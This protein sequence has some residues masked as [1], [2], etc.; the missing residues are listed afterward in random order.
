MLD[1]LI[2]NG[3]VIDGTGRQ[4]FRAGVG[5]TAGAIRLFVPPQP[6]PRARKIIDASGMVVA[7][8]F[9][10]MHGHSDIAL[11]KR[12]AILAK[13]MQGV[14][15]EV[16]G[17]CGFSPAP[18]TRETHALVRDLCIPMFG[19]GSV[20]WR[21]KRFGEFLRCFERQ[22]PVSN[23]VALVG[24][25]PVRI[26]A[27][28]LKKKRV[29][30]RAMKRMKYLL[31]EALSEGARGMSSGLIY[32]PGF[33]STEAELTELCKVVARHGGIYATHMR[34]EA[35]RLIESIEESIRTAAE[36]GVSLQI[37]HLKAAQKPNWGKSGEALRRI[38]KARGE[39]VD[40][41]FD[42]YPYT[43]GSTTLV[44]VLPDW[45]HEGG[46]RKL[47]KRV[48]TSESRGRL[49][50]EL[51]TN[52][53]SYWKSL[54]I[55]SVSTR[56]NK[57]FEG[58]TLDE[59]SQIR[60]CAP[61]EAV[62]DIIAEENGKV[63]MIGFSMCEEDVRQILKEPTGMI[64]TDG[65]H[66]SKP[67]PRLYGAFP[68]ILGRYV[69]QQKLL[70]LELAIK[71]MTSLP[72]DKLNLGSRGRIAEGYAADVVV[73]DPKTVIDT[74]TYEQ[75]V[76]FPKGIEHVIVNGKLVVHRGRFTGI[77]AGRVL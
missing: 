52:E 63:T 21:W 13:V 74:A 16:I 66:G 25:A 47:L 15:T 62:L 33:Y 19:D 61:E 34:N 20:R 40:V 60:G 46:M 58:K 1:I 14:T 41:G 28:G 42:Q 17:L 27:V 31:D 36:S 64:C 44:T 35:D 4:P 54:L 51:G 10:D 55:S 50:K 8:G 24:H 30:P 70:P 29:S 72:A 5:I 6:L 53:P 3:T 43:A 67:H 12:P 65:V 71:K 75:P 59:V 57:R 32:P 73:F 2:K 23:V 38:R 39:G 45:A 49:L 26:A 48:T 9:I 22:S 11:L 77:Y 68:R 37:S 76:R 7:P 18:L 69:R 56:R